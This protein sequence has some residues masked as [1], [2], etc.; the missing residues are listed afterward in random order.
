M[1][2]SKLKYG[3]IAAALGLPVAAR[4]DMVSEAETSIEGVVANITTLGGAMV[5][6]AAAWLLWG[7]VKK[8][9]RKSA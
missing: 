5:G 9:I 8:A 7:I 2:N 6:V 4:A 1:K 3:L